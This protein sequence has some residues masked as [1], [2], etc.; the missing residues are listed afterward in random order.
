MKVLIVRQGSSIFL[1]LKLPTSK[2]GTSMLKESI[3]TDD[4]P[5]LFLIFFLAMVLNVGYNSM[6]NISQETTRNKFL[7]GIVK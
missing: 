4:V 6:Q 3:F 7:G 1:S 2:N 5:P